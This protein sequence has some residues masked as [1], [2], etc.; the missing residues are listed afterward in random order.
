VEQI[1]H[2]HCSYKQQV[3]QKIS[4]NNEDKERKIRNSRKALDEK[5]DNILNYSDRLLANR[6][7][8]DPNHL[9]NYVQDLDRSLRD[10]TTVLISHDL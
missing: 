10:C 6:Y 9:S 2:V 7:E 4:M 5:M 1:L 3:K 8:F